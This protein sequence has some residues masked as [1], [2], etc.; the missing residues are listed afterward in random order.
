MPDFTHLVQLVILFFVIIDPF[1]SF[2]V[3]F[4]STR[5]FSPAERKKSALYAFLFAF[6]ICCSVLFAGERLL[7]LFNTTMDNFRVAGGIILCILGT[8]MALG[9]AIPEVDDLKKDSG[10]A[11]SAIIATPLI[12]G[13][14]CIT[15]IIVSTHDY[16]TLQTGIAAGIVLIITGA[17]LLMSGYIYKFLGDNAIRIISTIMG[18]ITTAW[19]VN[20]IRSGLGI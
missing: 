4:V 11:I 9:K 15:A 17:M 16:G 5:N 18:L 12:A 14:A 6:L 2:V 7:F 20:F 8:R 1:A 13:P 10:R 3:F 19:G